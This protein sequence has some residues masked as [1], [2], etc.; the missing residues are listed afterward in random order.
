M[1]FSE[2]SP[3]SLGEKGRDEGAAHQL[4]LNDQQVDKPQSYAYYQAID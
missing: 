4:H 2:K 1:E 3:F